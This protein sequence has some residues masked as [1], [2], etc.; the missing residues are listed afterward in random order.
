ME[1]TYEFIKMTNFYYENYYKDAEKKRGLI[2]YNSQIPRSIINEYHNNPNV[3][4]NDTPEINRMFIKLYSMNE[5]IVESRSREERKGIIDMYKY[6]QECDVSEI[7]DEILLK[8]HQKLY[9]HVV[10]PEYGGRYR[11]TSTFVTGAKDIGNV[12]YRQI[13]FLMMDLRS[14]FTEILEYVKNPNFN[15]IQYIKKVVELKCKIIKIHPFADGNGRTTR[16]LVN[17]LFKIV[18]L[19]SVYIEYEEKDIYLK[20]MEHATDDANFDYINNFYF[21][22]IANSIY[23]FGLRPKTELEKEF[24]SN[25]KNKML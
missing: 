7:F 4:I 22:R 5:D 1:E 6:I 25:M 18:K 3:T 23:E 8:L 20:A 16:A 19:P 14:E 12:Y 2:L 13:P 21:Y 9:S 11:E 10:Y 17:L 24:N 15:I